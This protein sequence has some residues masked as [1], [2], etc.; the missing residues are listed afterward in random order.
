M[1]MQASAS[2]HPTVEALIACGDGEASADTM[3]HVEACSMCAEQVASV[4]QIQGELRRSLYRFDCPDAQTL[5]DYQLDLLQPEQHMRVAAHAMDCD[6]CSV[7]LQTLRS[8]LAQPTS[9]AESPLQVARRIVARLFR[10]APGL[11]YG[12]L[13]GASETDTRV[14]QVDDITITVGPGHGSGSLVGLVLIAGAEPKAL[15]G[16]LV[17]LVPTDHL[18]LTSVLDD[19]GNFEFEGVP[20][21]SYALELHLPEALVVVEELRVD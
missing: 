11:A 6:A 10:P 14:Y 7:E 9:I 3:A 1:S 12:G 17:R 19:L 2:G 21:G 18:A 16:R 4:I 8:Y 13:R 5:G 20:A 15:D